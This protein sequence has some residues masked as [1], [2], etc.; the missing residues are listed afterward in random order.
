MKILQDTMEKS[1]LC[2]LHRV[3]QLWEPIISCTHMAL[4]QSSNQKID[5]QF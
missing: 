4:W 1:Q 5:K 3:I 2:F